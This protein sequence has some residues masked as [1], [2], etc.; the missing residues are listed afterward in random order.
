[1]IN[2]NTFAWLYQYTELNPTIGLYPHIPIDYKAEEQ[3][4]FLT[5]KEYMDECAR[6]TEIKNSIDVFL[7]VL[8]F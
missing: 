2:A 3:G 1:M 6:L 4:E 5:V 8:F 7:F